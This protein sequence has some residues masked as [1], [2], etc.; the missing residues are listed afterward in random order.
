MAMAH[1]PSVTRDDVLRI[2]RRDFSEQDRQVVLDLLAEYGIESWET[3]AD[4]VH[5]AILKL[6]NGSVEKVRRY[7]RIAKSD[8]RDVLGPAEYR[9]FY[10]LLPDGDSRLTRK[11]LRRIKEDDWEDYSRW[12]SRE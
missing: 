9:R 2:V 7:V 6:G 12:L 8:F 1:T 4:R 11:E 5:L 10:D 3:E